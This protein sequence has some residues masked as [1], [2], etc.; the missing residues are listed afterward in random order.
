MDFPKA[1]GE[2]ASA[3]DYFNIVLEAFFLKI[4]SNAFIW[5]LINYCA[6][7]LAFD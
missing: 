4:A 5:H 1:L 7:N 2:V 6:G 3:S